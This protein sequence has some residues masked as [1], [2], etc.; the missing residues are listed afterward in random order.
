MPLQEPP[1]HLNCPRCGQPLIP[2]SPQ[3]PAD[4]P[5]YVCEEHG[6]FELTKT[7]LL[8]WGDGTRP[9]IANI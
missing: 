7:G 3:A 2:L 1:L 5:Y 4:P 8:E 9:P 6:L